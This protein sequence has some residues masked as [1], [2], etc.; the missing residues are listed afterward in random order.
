VNLQ[1]IFDRLKTLS[2]TLTVAQRISLVLTFVGVVALVSGSAYLMN[3][4]DYVLLFSEL[5]AESAADVVGRL[6]T[7][8]VPYQLTDGGKSV[9]VP[10]SR[11]DELRLDFASQGMPG[12]GRIGFEIFDKLSFGATEFLEQVNF[13]RALEGEIART[14]STIAEVSSARVH[15]AIAKSS[16]FESREQPAKASVVLKLKGNRVL[17]ASTARGISGLVASAVEGLRPESVVILDSHGRSLTKPSEDPDGSLGAPSMERQLAVERDLT[18]RL[19]AL[20]DP[21]VGPDRVRV[22]VSARLNAQTEEQTEERWD[23]NTAVVRSRQ[24]SADT[25]TVGNPMGGVAGVRGNQP[26]AAPA[27]PPATPA[28][29]PPA[30]P[31]EI[32]KVVSDAKLA[33][34]SAETTNYEISHTTRRTVKPKGEIARLSVAVILDDKLELITGKDGVVTRKYKPRER[35][36]LQRIQN[37]VSAAAG[38]DTARG[39][40]LTVENI[41]FDDRPVVDEVVKPTF[42]EQQS[43]RLPELGRILGV[44]VLGLFAFLLV[45]RPVMKRA[46]YSSPTAL[47]AAEVAGF[48]AALP[49]PGGAAKTIRDLEGAFEA[50]LVAAESAQAEQRRVPVLTKRIG[51][52]TQTEPDHAARM[53]RTWLTEDRKNG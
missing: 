22:N 50:E 41:A 1:Q 45:V 19:V 51:T 20:L 31:P 10:Q 5:D 44:V 23:P 36:E 26:D 34:R 52:L 35:E 24:T 29:A 6:K 32:P 43:P 16:L 25:T 18:T 13:R 3:K 14:I 33:G 15:I 49:G 17:S 8:K 47:A 53:I 21:V 27:T 4:Q 9:R 38:V 40:Q 48:S 42:W 12:S 7:A 2:A 37:S 30:P 28:G 39:D 11:A 46:L